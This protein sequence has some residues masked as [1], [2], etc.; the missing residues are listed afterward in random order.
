MV[1]IYKGDSLGAFGEDGIT[2]NLYNPEH[3]TIAKAEFKVGNLPTLIINNPQF[4]LHIN[5]DKK[6][7]EYLQQQNSCYLAVYDENGNKV[8]CKGVFNIVA[9]DKVV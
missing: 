9:K 3:Y 8:T 1:Q 7:T 5:I 4:P 2:V 6:D